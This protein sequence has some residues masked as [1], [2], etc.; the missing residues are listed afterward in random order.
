MDLSETTYSWGATT[1]SAGRARDA[2]PNRGP[3]KGDS[4]SMEQPMPLPRGLHRGV[5]P[6]DRRESI[7]AS[8]AKCEFS[9]FRSSRPNTGGSRHPQLRSTREGRH[10]PAH[11]DR[12]YR[13]SFNGAFIAPVHESATAG[14]S[15]SVQERRQPSEA[16]TR[17]PPNGRLPSLVTT[18]GRHGVQR[19]S[20]F[21]TGGDALTSVQFNVV[22][23]S[24]PVCRVAPRRSGEKREV[25]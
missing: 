25:H 2:A 11:R 8:G 17:E 18:G 23:H 9:P 3:A 13:L 19:C 15:V 10:G 7:R 24:D 16:F 5:E 20:A 1:R 14:T 21:G 4:C 22:L 12:R 6:R